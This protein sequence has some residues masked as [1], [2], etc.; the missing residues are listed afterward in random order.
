MSRSTFVLTAAFAVVGATLVPAVAGAEPGV[1]ATTCL[2]KPVTIVATPDATVGTEGDDVVAMTPSGWS[3]FD[4]RGGNDTICLALGMAFNNPRDS[5]PPTGLLD[6]GAGD[7]VVVNEATESPGA[8]MSV[9]LGVGEDTFTGNGTPASVFAD[10]SVVYGLP[11]S[12]PAG[13]QRDLID[14]GTGGGAV[15][16]VA[17]VG[18]LNEDRIVFGGGAAQVVYGGAMGPSGLVDVTA[19]GSSPSLWL[20]QPGAVEPVG[21]GELTIDNVGRRATVGGAQVMTWSGQFSTFSFGQ[22]GG[23]SSGLPV[24]FVGSEADEDVTVSGGPVGDIRLGGGDDSLSVHAYNDAFVPRSADG[25]PGSDSAVLE[26]ACVTM[27]VAVTRDISCDGFSGPFGGFDEVIATSLRSGSTVS[28]VGSAT[29]ERLVASGGRVTVHGRG[30]ADEIGVD[31]ASTTRVSGGGGADD[32]WASGGDVIVKGQTGSDRIELL[33]PEGG[34]AP[35]VTR[36]VALGG[37]GADQLRGT[38]ETQGDRLVGGRG[39]DQANGKGGKHDRC[40]AEATKNCER[41]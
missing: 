39:K 34:R 27:R 36:Q 13:S 18:G 37:R 33:G 25:G 35:A 19:A 22:D 23:T 14:A 1:A 26:T 31:D 20:P 15:T 29:A 38:D 3:T 8:T 17:P 40:V 9:G 11:P 5:I 21:R 10:S 28:L 16:S 12:P 24:S 6:A 30:G 32:I 7:D 4:A 41:I 2:G